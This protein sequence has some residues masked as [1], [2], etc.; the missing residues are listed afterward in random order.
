[1]AAL[2]VPVVGVFGFLAVQAAHQHQWGD[3]VRDIWLAVVFLGIPGLGLM[4]LGR[5]LKGRKP[6]DLPSSPS[7]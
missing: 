3:A 7:L 5:V 6:P 4:W 2:C 1:V